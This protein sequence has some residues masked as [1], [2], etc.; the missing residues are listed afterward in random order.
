MQNKR[1][2]S[3]QRTRSARGTTF[4]GYGQS[5]PYPTSAPYRCACVG[6]M[7]HPAMLRSYL[8]FPLCRRPFQPRRRLSAARFERTPLPHRT[9]STAIK[10]TPSKKLLSRESAFD[11]RQFQTVY[12]K[13]R[14]RFCI[15][16]TESL[17]MYDA[18]S[19]GAGIRSTRRSRPWNTRF[20]IAPA[21]CAN[22]LAASSII[23]TL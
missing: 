8:P 18:I 11:G 9:Y 23:S 3:S 16:K 15:S 22:M 5:Q 4:V 21:P 6:A 10:Y 14:A 20:V 2:F 19:L 17:L 1:R 13:N 7:F 12:C